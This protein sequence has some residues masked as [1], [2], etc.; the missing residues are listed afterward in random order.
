M[1]Y[2]AAQDSFAK[3]AHVPDWII[4]QTVL[5]LSLH[6][7]KNFLSGLFE[8][9]KLSVTFPFH[10]CSNRQFVNRWS[11]QHSVAGSTVRMTNWY[12]DWQDSYCKQNSSGTENITGVLDLENVLLLVDRFCP[13]CISCMWEDNILLSPA[14][15]D[16][17]FVAPGIHRSIAPQSFLSPTLMRPLED[18]N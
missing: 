3:H 4:I 5:F 12:W 7:C 15:E 6:G 11:C 17:S 10:Y 1:I 18:R 8:A 13:I 9:H 14:L 2:F 16:M